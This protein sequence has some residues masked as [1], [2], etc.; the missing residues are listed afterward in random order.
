[1]NKEIFNLPNCL[2]MARILAAPIIVFLLYV[3]MWFQFKIGAYCAFGVFF[4]ASVTDYLDG[5]IARKT[6]VITN[7]GKFLD[8]LADKLLIGSVLIMLVRL[9][10]EWRVPAWI[11]IIIICREL[12]VT[13]MRAIAA[14]MGEVVAADKFGKAKTLIQ[15]LATGFLVFHYPFFG[16]DVRPIG[17]VLLWLA[18][19]LTVFSG[20]NYLY[21]FYKKWL[22]SEEN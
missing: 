6:G 21:N 12:A 3:E 8:P 16:V 5:K 9:G 20:G 22:N 10:P 19:A 17:Q 18:L 11:V 15:S 7:L 14:E 1:M 4:L 13:G 2:T